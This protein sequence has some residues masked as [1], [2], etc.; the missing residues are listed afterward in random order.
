MKT[1]HLKLILGVLLL[2]SICT[3]T[4]CGKFND[5][6]KYG[7]IQ[8]IV[9]NFNTSEPLQG[10]NVT[11][12]PTGLSAVTGSDGRYEFNNIQVGQYTV[13]GVKTGFDTNTKS[14]VV[15]EN[16]VASGDMQLK[17]TVSGFRLSVE[18]LDFGN[19]FNTLSFKIINV[20]STLPLSWEIMESMNWLTV[21]PQ[22][23]NLAGGQETTVQV[24]ID[25]KLI[26]QSTTA[27]ITVRTADQTVILPVSVSI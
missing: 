25:R 10:V 7:R 5:D 9:T 20:S 11:L 15:A 8:G 26:Q 2:L 22:T 27:N 13:Q 1:K 23:G 16:G 19:A 18:Y 12:S 24:E 4:S 14:I 6:P 3:M 17:P 21:T